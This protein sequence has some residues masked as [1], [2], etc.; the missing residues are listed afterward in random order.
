[1]I[2][3]CQEV[4]VAVILRETLTD[5]YQ[6]NSSKNGILIEFRFMQVIFNFHDDSLIVK[7]LHQ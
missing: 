6:R 2:I 4:V 7:N 3:P 5:E 1:M